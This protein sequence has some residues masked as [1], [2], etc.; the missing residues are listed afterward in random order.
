MTTL[1][2]EGAEK[3]LKRIDVDA[4]RRVQHTEQRNIKKDRLDLEKLGKGYI[5]QGGAAK[6]L[7]QNPR[8]HPMD[9]QPPVGDSKGL[10]Q[11]YAKLQT[12]CQELAN[13]LTSE[14]SARMLGMG[15]DNLTG[16]VAK[17]YE[18]LRKLEDARAD[19]KT[20]QEGLKVK[21]ATLQGEYDSALAAAKQT[22]TA[23]NLQAKLK[24]AATNLTDYLKGLEDTK[25]VVDQVK[26]A[27]GNTVN[28]DL[29][30]QAMGMG[31]GYVGDLV[32]AQVLQTNL[33]ALL[34]QAIDPA[35]LTEAETEVEKR[36]Q[37]Y[38]LLTIR[39]VD[40]FARLEEVSSE[41]TKVPSPNALLIGI[42]YQRYRQSVARITEALID[43]RLAKQSAALSAT[44][45]ELYQLWV[46]AKASQ[47]MRTASC[48]V[49]AIG[50]SDFMSRCKGNR[51]M[52]LAAATALIAYDHAW[53]L[54]QT[55]QSS[56]AMTDS[57]AR[58][59]YAVEMARVSAQ[60]WF[61]LLAPA[62]QELVAYG[63]GGLRQETIGNLIG[64][65]GLAAI[66][67]GV[68]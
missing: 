29:I 43:E 10:R 1:L 44:I 17:T 36:A 23:A 53:S 6:N 25:R 50:F 37:T 52:K 13:Q 4:L 48:G 45:E 57:A 64:A 12:S 68:Y 22:P 58:Q 35:K 66:A 63:E 67:G 65:I 41:P 38:Y 32:Q 28:L 42:A 56:A 33:S 24:Q 8:T 16:E 7:C 26:E 62:L 14:E 9:Q 54:G 15:A 60:A 31:V 61:D 3:F 11:V 19:L 40:T 39:A 47:S 27:T 21:L 30:Q 49:K 59:Q 46:A 20:A 5:A 18:L 34:K 55:E 51:D 2:G